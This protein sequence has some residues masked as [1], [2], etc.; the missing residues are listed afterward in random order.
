[1]HAIGSVIDI[2]GGKFVICGY[3]PFDNAG[4]VG[5]GYLVVPYPL[6][7]VDVDSFSVVAADTYYP[8]VHEGYCNKDSEDYDHLLEQVRTYGRETTTQ[9]VVAAT[10]EGSAELASMATNKAEGE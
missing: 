2:H 6:G 3:R 1:M 5:M 9:E 4:M 8:V 10:E 7:F